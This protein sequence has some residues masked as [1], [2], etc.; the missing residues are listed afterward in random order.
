VF[1]GKHGQVALEDV[2]NICTQQIL[3]PRP[4][5]L[6]E[7][8]YEANVAATVASTLARWSMYVRLTCTEIG[9]GEL[10]HITDD[11]A[12]SKMQAGLSLADQR[13]IGDHRER[14]GCACCILDVDDLY[15]FR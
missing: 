10:I 4:H 14:G 13:G 3:S 7:G 2:R 8:P 6:N 11:L 15:V 1:R 12:Q 5:G 9:H